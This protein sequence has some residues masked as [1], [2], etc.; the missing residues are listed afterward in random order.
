[1]SKSDVR[2]LWSQPFPPYGKDPDVPGLSCSC[3]ILLLPITLDDIIDH[4]EE[5][6]YVNRL[7]SAITALPRFRGDRPAFGQV[8][9]GR[10]RNRPT[11]L[12]LI[13]KWAQNGLQPESAVAGDFSE[14]ELITI[15][16]Q[17]NTQIQVNLLKLINCN[18]SKELSPA[19]GLGPLIYEF[20]MIR[21]PNEAADTERQVFTTSLSTIDRVT[22]DIFGSHR[23]DHDPPDLASDRR[24]WTTSTEA[25]QR[26]TEHLIILFWTS[27]DDEQRFKDPMRESHGTNKI[28]LEQDL[29]TAQFQAALCDMEHAHASI[30]SVRVKLTGWCDLR[31]Q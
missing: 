19:V 12:V 11:E 14:Q 24:A 10:P 5:T 4:H 28:L 3:S 20:I 18:L 16:S 9:Y 31:F 30:M 22:F 8:W 29:W 7:C 1:M 27:E 26:F 21:F 25:D 23:S 2:S 6:S 13:V 15:L 17:R